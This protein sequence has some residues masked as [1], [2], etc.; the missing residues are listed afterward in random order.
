MVNQDVPKEKRKSRAQLFFEERKDL[1][2]PDM[3][4]N[5]IGTLITYEEEKW[6]CKPWVSEWIGVIRSMFFHPMRIV[7]SVP[8]H[9]DDAGYWDMA[10]FMSGLE[11][12]IGELTYTK[13]KRRNS[14]GAQVALRNIGYPP[15]VKPDIY[16]DCIPQ[17]IIETVGHSDLENAR[18]IVYWRPSDSSIEVMGKFGIIWNDM[19]DKLIDM[20]EVRF[21][22]APED[23][24]TAME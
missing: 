14:L 19:E 4:I 10:I 9:R 21:A 18:R 23:V 17:R 24:I 22:G 20:P 12:K 8:R 15:G 5:P 3:V 6:T 1:K 11:K 7:L 2:K 16:I 13:E